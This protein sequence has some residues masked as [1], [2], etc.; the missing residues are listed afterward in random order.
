M[1]SNY[2]EN[3]LGGL[4]FIYLYH[5]SQGIPLRKYLLVLIKIIKLRA[6]TIRIKRGAFYMIIKHPE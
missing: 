3:N 1:Y 6:K 4:D 2:T 5:I